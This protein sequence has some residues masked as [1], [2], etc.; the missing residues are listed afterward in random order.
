MARPK[1]SDAPD[2]AQCVNLTAGTI[3]RLTCP[4]GK[5][6]AFLR[7]TEAPSLRVRVMASGVKSY[8]FGSKLNRQ[9]I[10]STIG[11]VSDWTIDAARVEARRLTVLIDKCIDP[12][13]LA[14]EEAAAKV[15][16]EE[17]VTAEQAAQNAKAIAD[18]VTFGQAWAHCC[19][20]RA[21]HWSER[22]Q[23]DH[24]AMTMP[25]GEERKRRPG[26]LTKP[27][28]LAHFVQTRLVDVTAEAIELW[29]RPEAVDR[30][31]RV[32]LA[33]RQ[34]KAFLRWAADERDYR[35]R[36]DP[37]AASA[38]KTREAAG[39]AKAKRDV[40][41]RGQLQAWF[42]AVRA[43]Q[44]P[45]AAAYLQTLLL[46]GA[47]MNEVQA[48]RWDDISWKWRSN[49]LGDKVDAMTNAPYRSPIMWQACFA[50]CR[51]GTVG[52][53]QASCR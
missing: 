6:Q 24:R 26:V 19:A 10:R 25:G 29:A 52:S 36:V 23:D 53:S 14:R 17:R 41:E 15:S 34:R 22:N 32:R 27:G 38:K 4:S 30:A 47:R 45:V 31:A 7:D 39:K 44:N 28:P 51:G 48:L 1:K 37:A 3:E 46:T 43:I 49:T 12:R 42:G 9:N 33:L 2:L 16:E 40:L 11:N 50:G 5:A 20:E 8:V 18:A 35:G 13:A 21:R